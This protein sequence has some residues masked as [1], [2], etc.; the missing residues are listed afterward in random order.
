[1]PIELKFFCWSNENNAVLFVLPLKYLKHH[2]YHEGQAASNISVF[3]ITHLD[4][5]NCFRVWAR[6]EHNKPRFVTSINATRGRIFSNR[7]PLK[8]TSSQHHTS[9]RNTEGCTLGFDGV[10]KETWSHILSNVEVKSCLEKK[11]TKHQNF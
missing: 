4:I 6:R 5:I 7:Y 11:T 1:M 8:K 3:K 2:V 9:H 10:F